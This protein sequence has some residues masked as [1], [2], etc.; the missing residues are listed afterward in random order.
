MSTVYDVLSLTWVALK[1]HQ[2]Q[3]V[4][5]HT[6]VDTSFFL[7]LFYLFFISEIQMGIS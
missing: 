7:A 2:I 4:L 3:S 1:L 6:D 5:T